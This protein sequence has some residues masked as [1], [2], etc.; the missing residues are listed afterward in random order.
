MAQSSVFS[1]SQAEQG[2]SNT[3]VRRFIEGLVN[4]CV[5]APVAPRSILVKMVPQTDCSLLSWMILPPHMANNPQVYTFSPNHTT[6]A[7]AHNLNHHL[8]LDTS[9]QLSTEP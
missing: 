4:P 7:K 1:L 6:E 3:D 9:Q 8:T 5:P 2:F